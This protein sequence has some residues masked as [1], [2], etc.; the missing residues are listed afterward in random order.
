[1]IEFLTLGIL[2]VLCLSRLGSQPLR[3]DEARTALLAERIRAC[4]LPRVRSDTLSLFPKTE[5]AQNGLCLL[6][7]PLQFY[8]AYL[9]RLTGSSPAAFRLPFALAGL[10]AAGITGLTGEHLMPGTGIAAAA[11]F[12]QVPYL[13]LIR[14]ARHY[15]LVL[16]ATALTLWGL[17]SGSLVGAA[18]GGIVLAASEWSAYLATLAGA[19]FAV[20]FGSWPVHEVIAFAA[21]ILIL[22]PWAWLRSSLPRPVPPHPGNRFDG[23]LEAFWTYFWKLNGLFVPLALLTLIAWA[24]GTLRPSPVLGGLGWIVMAH[25]ALRSVT[26][27][28]F[29]RYLS[30]ALV[31]ASLFAGVLLAGIAGRSLAL[32]VLITLTI[33]A[34]DA[35]HR[36]P[37]LLSR[38]AYRWLACLRC[39][40]GAHFAREAP[41][42]ARRLPRL[43]LWEFILELARPPRLRTTGLASALPAGSRVVLGQTE[44]APLQM[45]APSL[46]VVPW[47]IDRKNELAWLQEHPPDVIVLG[48]LDRPGQ[49]VSHLPGRYA[50]RILPIPDTLMANGETLERH[51]FRDPARP[52]GVEILQRC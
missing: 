9:G 20:L 17:T 45:A 36:F 8:V 52:W 18:A 24:A 48:D 46:R 34:S 51:L 1:M 47:G 2:G 16:C 39:P 44:A 37:L 40:G 4:G 30:G 49:L 41:E 32:A 27:A 43:L 25:L 5:V 31:P 11:T 19:L 6:H 14:Q 33:V 15:S 22:L 13:L 28:V 29:A 10:V 35:L 12:L 42:D 7:T 3:L 23:T 50:A 21:G 26:P 38:R